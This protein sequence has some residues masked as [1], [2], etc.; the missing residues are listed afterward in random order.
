[1]FPPGLHAKHPPRRARFP[2]ALYLFAVFV[3]SAQGDTF[4]FSADRMTGGRAVGREVTI[5]TG[6]AEVHSDSLF[7]KADRIEIHGDNNQFIDCTGKVWGRDE[8]KDILFQ[9]DRLRY[10]RKL[11]I[12]RLEGNSTLEDK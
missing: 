2:L 5:L 8:E 9:T 7:L 12:A 11:K 3:M 1:M 4:T 6:S 10:D